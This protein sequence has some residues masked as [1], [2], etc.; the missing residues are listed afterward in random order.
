ML[1]TQEISPIFIVGHPR[2]GSTLLASIMGEHSRI[3][4]LPETHFVRSS[5][6]GGTPIQRWFA[7][8]SLASKV[9][10]IFSNVRL[11]DAG[12]TSERFEFYCRNSN[13]DQRSSAQLLR[14][15]L[16]LCREQFGKEFVLEKTPG[17]IVHVKEILKWMPKAKIIY[18]VRDARDAVSS[19]LRVKWTHSNPKRHAAYWALCVRM[20]HA[21]K[22]AYPDQVHVVRYEDLLLDSMSSMRKICEFVGV[23]Y[24]EQMLGDKRAEGVV[25]DWEMEWKKSSKSRIDPAHANQWKAAGNAVLCDLVE[26]CA[27]SEMSSLGYELSKGDKHHSL[28]DGLRKR[29][30]DKYVEVGVVYR[31]YFSGKKNRFRERALKESNS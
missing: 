10:L 14:A 27:Y 7:N 2:S 28:W 4:A 15:F 25:P 23:E 18:T 9:E 13:V 31:E 20:A 3:A 17:H 11:P 12:I 6:Y 30:Y 1:N 26:Q 22:Q 8:R 24:Q 29:A 16:L 19:L 21:M 5:L